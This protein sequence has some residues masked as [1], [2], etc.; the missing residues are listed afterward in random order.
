[1]NSNK[2]KKKILIM[3]D[4]FHQRVLLEKFLSK[5]GYDVLSAENGVEGLNYVNTFF[6]DFI[7]LDYKMPKMNGLQ[8]ARYLK[9]N[10]HKAFIIFI[11]SQ[12]IENTYTYFLPKPINLFELKSL[13]KNLS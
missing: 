9:K 8:V 2:E 11:T 13:I 10:G 4:N 3:E 1:M 7:L 6:P 5:E 12:Y